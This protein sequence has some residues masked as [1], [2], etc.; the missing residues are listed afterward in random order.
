MY[1]WR[2]NT[3]RKERLP[4]KALHSARKRSISECVDGFFP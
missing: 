4:A 1:R 2:K 3:R